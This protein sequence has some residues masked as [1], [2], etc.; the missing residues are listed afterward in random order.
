MG[1]LWDLRA[2]SLEHLHGPHQFGTLRKTTSW[3]VVPYI[4]LLSQPCSCVTP[5]QPCSLFICLVLFLGNSLAN[6]Q[7]TTKRR[8]ERIQTGTRGTELRNKG[9]TNATENLG[10]TRTGPLRA[11]RPPIRRPTHHSEEPLF[12]QKNSRWN[13]CS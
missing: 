6:K 2:R 7:P 5:I 8:D 4:R 13:L 11:C 9:E 1:F 12:E 3:M 10:P